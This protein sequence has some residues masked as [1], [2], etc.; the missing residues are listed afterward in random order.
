MKEGDDIAT[1]FLRVDEI[2]NVMRGPG[3]EIK[4]SIIVQNILR[5][6]PMRIDPKVSSLEERS[7][8]AMLSIDELHG[9]L[10]TYK[11]RTKQDNPS[12]REASFKASKKTRK[13]KQNLKSSSYCS[14]DSNENE[15]IANFERRL[16]KGIGKYKG[17][18]P[19]K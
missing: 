6:I 4:G 15:E 16:K 5:S 8:L 2:V 13:N 11:V 19:L 10:T 3:E 18:I 12:K 7:Y 14:N 17:K 9:I 1:Y